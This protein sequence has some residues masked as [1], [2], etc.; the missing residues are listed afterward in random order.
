MRLLI[1]SQ[2]SGT[3]SHIKNWRAG[4]IWLLQSLLAAVVLVLLWQ[5]A[6]TVAELKPQ[7]NII[8]VVVDDSRSMSIADDGTPREEQAVKALQNGVLSE[9]Q[10]SYQTRIYS[11]D[12]RATRVGSLTELHPTASITRIGDSLKQLVAET[13]DLPIGAIV[14]L[15]D[16]GDN[17]GGIDLDTISALRNRHIPVHTVGF[18]LEQ[19]PDDVEINDAVVAPRALADSRLVRDGHFSPARLCG[20]ESHAGCSRRR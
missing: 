3:A 6:I 20:A 19:M 13:S 11:L 10:K 1:R 16:G 4:A 17:S 14:L 8:A 2:L 7:Q 15:S 5:P 12:S 9:L 18:G